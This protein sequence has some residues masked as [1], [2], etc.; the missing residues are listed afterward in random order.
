MNDFL[1]VGRV[2]DENS[3]ECGMRSAECGVGRRWGRCGK[4]PY[5]IVVDGYAEAFAAEHEP[6]D[7]E[8]PILEP[9]DVRMWAVVKIEQRAGGDEEAQVRTARLGAQVLRQLPKPTDC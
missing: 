1:E 6:E 4:R 9:S 8:F 3:F 2:E 7:A 5:L